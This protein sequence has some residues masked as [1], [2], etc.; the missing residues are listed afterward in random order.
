MVTVKVKIHGIIC[1]KRH[2]G[3]IE[4]SSTL[5]LTYGLD[6][7]GWLPPRPERF[8]P[9]NDPVSIEWKARWAPRPVW[10]GA[11]NLAPAGIRYS[12]RPARSTVAIPTEL[13]RPLY[14]QER[15]GTHCTG[16]WV[17]PRAGLDGCGKSRFTPGFDPRTV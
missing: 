2:R 5:S 6:G 10:M 17:G 4:F 8:T 1:Q 3:G 13:S 16:G 7:S 15:P 11:E 9:G 14:P 12:E